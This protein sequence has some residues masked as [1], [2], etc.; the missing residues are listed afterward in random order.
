M[1][2]KRIKSV[3][4]KRQQRLNYYNRI[5]KEIEKELKESGQWFC[6]FSGLPLPQESSF[7]PHHLRGRKEEMLV[8]RDFLVPCLW[9]Y[10]R[11]WHDEPLSKLKNEWWFGGFLE[12][13]KERDKDGYIAL[14]LKL[15]DLDK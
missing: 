15:K 4:T 9:E 11:K 2:Q 6:F 3:S 1:V 14:I 5:K 7:L 12:R 8:E 13:L 10:H